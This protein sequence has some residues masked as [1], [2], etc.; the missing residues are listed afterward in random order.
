M[1]TAHTTRF[2]GAYCLITVLFLSQSSFADWINLSGAET[3]ENIAEITILDDRVEI[4]LEIYLDD[5]DA[6]ERG[7]TPEIFALQVIADGVAIEPEITLRERRTR[8]DRISPYAGMINPQTRQRIPGPPEDKR[9][10]YVQLEYRLADRPDQLTL[11]PP[12]DKDGNAAVTIGF[13]AYHK[14]APIIDFR[15][16][17]QAETVILDWDDPWFSSFENMNLT[18]HH[19]WPLMSFLYVEP[20]QVRHEVLMR[21]RDLMEWTEF[22]DDGQEILSAE[23]KDRLKGVAWDF[24]DDRNP[25]RIDGV[26]SKRSTSRAEFLRI[27]PT[28]LQVIEETDPVDVSAAIMGIIQSYWIERLP[29]N[30]SVRWELF[31]EQNDTIPVTVSDPAGPFPGFVT[32][33]D[34][35]IEWQNF[36]KAY[37]EPEISPVIVDDGRSKRVPVLTLLLLG[38]SI[39]AAALAHRQ[40]RLRK[41]GWF[42]V[43]AACA[44]AAV[45]TI[46]VAIVEVPNP[47]A[48][49]PDEK[50]AAQVVTGVLNNVNTAF[51]EKNPQAFDRVLLGIVADNE[52]ASVAAELKRAFAIRVTGGGVATVHGIEDLQIANITSL[53]G[54]DGFR[55]LASW[56]AKATGRHWGHVDL[57]DIRFRALMEFGFVDG[58]WKLA[59][60]TVVDA[61]PVD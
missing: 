36:L 52:L 40:T 2:V 44:V 22:P 17:S 28:G 8:I 4:A 24:F 3:A 49:L 21:V 55:V 54:V 1:G 56:V 30:V 51:L 34:P 27:S 35:M 31:D 6:F 61:Q 9:V 38:L 14:A 39:T 25:L 29:Q 19:K 32:R 11:I 20:R 10:H 53:D 12:L 37:N 26:L 41:R 16:L 60:L 5:V 58:A 23:E 33:D 46:R 42:A 18:R 15:Y 43:S 48:G 7:G 59:G 13:L 50:A 47:L 57:R 45:V